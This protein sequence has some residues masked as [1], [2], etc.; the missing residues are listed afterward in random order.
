MW[1]GL[2]IERITNTVRNYG[3]VKELNGE[4]R[5]TILLSSLIGR[6]NNEWE[7]KL[8]YWIRLDVI[9]V[10][11]RYHTFYIEFYEA[12]FLCLSILK[13]KNLQEVH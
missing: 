10:T 2:E 6:N 4:K 3:D 13:K 5:L 8:F 7:D 9:E 1:I 12:S 11:N